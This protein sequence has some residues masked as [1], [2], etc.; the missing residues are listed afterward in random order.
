MGR[1]SKIKQKEIMKYIHTYA[2]HEEFEAN[3]PQQK[4]SSMNFCK[5]E[6]HIDMFGY[7]LK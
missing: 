1:I 5:A 6:N 2:N 4:H 7:P 3:V